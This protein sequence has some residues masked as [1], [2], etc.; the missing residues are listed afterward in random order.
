MGGTYEHSLGFFPTLAALAK[1]ANER[2]LRVHGLKDYENARDELQRV[3]DDTIAKLNVHEC[4][5]DIKACINADNNSTL[6]K[7]KRGRKKVE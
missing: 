1:Y 7:K 6:T 4:S 5:S 2:Q 3:L